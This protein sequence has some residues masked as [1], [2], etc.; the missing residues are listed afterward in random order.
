[1]ILAAIALVVGMMVGDFVGSKIG[2]DAGALEQGRLA[3]KK[4]AD[5]MDNLLRAMNRPPAPG[6]YPGKIYDD[7]GI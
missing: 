6:Q 7:Y 1:M 2:Y 4:G 3:Y 5:G